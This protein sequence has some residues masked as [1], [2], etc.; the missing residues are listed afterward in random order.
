[1][2]KMT[3]DQYQHAISRNFPDLSIYSLSIFGEGWANC[4]C[5]VNNNLIF[6][7]PLDAHAEQQ[8]L[9]EIRLLPVLAPELPLPIPNYQYIA[10]ASDAYPYPFVGY[11]LI[12]GTSF[13]Q[14]NESLRQATWWRPAVGKFLSAL[15]GVLIYKVVAVGLHGC[16][17]AQAWR[18]AVAQKHE[19]YEQHV[20]PLLTKS[21]RQSISHYLHTAI[22]DERMVSFSPVVLHQDFD[23][24]NILVDFNTQQVT[25]VLDFGCCSIGDPVLDVSPEIQPYYGGVIDPGWNF[26]RDYYKRTSALEDLLY[27]CTCE[28]SLPNGDAVRSRKLLEIARIWSP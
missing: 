1:M 9:G 21:Q 4:L 16:Q 20:Y 27:I 13:L 7:F 23:F 8:L 26:R 6:R 25:G 22:R 24:H 14:A 19:P 2:A 5:L 17:T 10:P 28:H 11:P 18:D 12:P 3:E 15:H